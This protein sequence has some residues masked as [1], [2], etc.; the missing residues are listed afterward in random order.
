MSTLSVSSFVKD[1]AAIGLRAGDRVMVHAWLQATCW[2]AMSKRRNAT[3]TRRKSCWS[4]AAPRRDALLVEDRGAMLP[5][6]TVSSLTNDV[7]ARLAGRRSRRGARVVQA[8][9]HH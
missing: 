4:R 2:P 5:G 3:W 6:V 8:A 7:A 1:L 9:R